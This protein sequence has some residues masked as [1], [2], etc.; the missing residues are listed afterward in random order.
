MPRRF[1]V[2]TDFDAIDGMSPVMRKMNRGFGRFATNI[3]DKNSLIGRSFGNVNRIINRGLAVGMIALAG[4]TALAAVEYIKLDQT[5]VGANA[6]FKDTVL[7]SEQATENLTLLSKAAREVGKTTQFTAVQAAQGLNFYAKA[8]FTTVEAMEVLADT[9][10]LATVAQSD[11]NRTADISSDLLGALGKNVQDS[12][13]KIQNLKDI[14]RALGITANAANVDLEDM[15]ETLKIAGPIA[16]AAGEGMHELFAITGA[17]GSAGIKGSLA[18]TA[19]KNSYIRLAAP[20]DAVTAALTKL[21][22]QQSD[23]IDQSGAMKS[24][25]TIMGMI[26]KASEGLGKADQ[27]AAFSEIFGKRAVAGATNLSKSLAEVESIMQRLESETNLK[28]LADEIR[29]G[30]GNQILILKSGVLELGLQFIEA[31]QKDG[32]GALQGMIEAVQNLD[33]QPIINFT[34]SVVEVLKFVGS[35]WELLLAFAGGIKAVGIAIAAVELATSLFGLTL[36]ASPVGAFIVTVGLLT[37]AIILL[38]TKWDELETMFANSKIGKILASGGGGAF[39]EG[40][41]EARRQRLSERQAAN[42]ANDPRFQRLS[43]RQAETLGTPETPTPFSGAGE[44]TNGTLDININNNAGDN[45]EITQSGT[46]PTGTKLN[47][48]PSFSF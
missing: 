35:N 20:T 34:K 39:S 22:L 48:T 41:E 45:A 12:A 15:F 47:F 29:K 31:F 6:R 28:S 18:A 36:A 26:G 46:V 10:D 11:F 3:T 32:R 14:N 30:L 4:A 2:Q 23:F 16:T 1:L 5:I 8:G 7:G 19:L 21:G 27:L 9:V 17:L 40:F 42:R 44:N 43:E 24:M 25:V 33:I 38:I 37:T 13:T